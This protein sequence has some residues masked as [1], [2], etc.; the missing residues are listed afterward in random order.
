[1]MVSARQR[2]CCSSSSVARRT[3]FSMDTAR[4]KS[5]SALPH[6]DLTRP[7]WQ[8]RNSDISLR[9]TVRP[10]T[11]SLYPASASDALQAHS[12][13]HLLTYSIRRARSLRLH[14]SSVI[15]LHCGQATQWLNG[16]TDDPQ[17]TQ[18][19]AGRQAGRQTD[20]RTSPLA[21]T[22]DTGVLLRYCAFT[23]HRLAMSPSLDSS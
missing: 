14:K 17:R 3:W 4:V 21:N 8:C 16:W 12:L 15:I 20:R 7:S 19:D 10:Q 2:C 6:A 9:Q 13:T 11:T 23:P 18:R 1:M 5:A 22:T